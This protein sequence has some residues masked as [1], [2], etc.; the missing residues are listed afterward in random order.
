MEIINIKQITSTLLNKIP[1]F[2]KI[3]TDYPASIEDFPCAIYTTS[4]IPRFIDDNGNELQTS[5]SITI[6]LITDKGSLTLIEN[7]VLAAFSVIGFS[8]QVR[9]ANMAFLK[10]DVIELKAVVDNGIKYVY[11]N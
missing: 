3:A 10:R 4:H 6:E 7:K 11:K 8:G 2:K 5:W 1:E 9:G